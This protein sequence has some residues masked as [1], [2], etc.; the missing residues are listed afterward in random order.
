VAYYPN[1]DPERSGP[2]FS[3]APQFSAS[4]R[5]ARFVCAFCTPAAFTGAPRALRRRRGT[6]P[7]SY[8]S[9]RSL[10]GPSVPSVSNSS[11][12][13]LFSV[14]LVAQ[15]LL[16]TLSFERSALL[17][18]SSPRSWVSLLHAPGF[19]FSAFPLRSQRLC[20]MFLFPS[21]FPSFSLSF[22][23]S[24]FLPLLLSFLLSLSPSFFPSFSLSFF[25]SLLLSLSYLC[26]LC[27]TVPL[28]FASW[29]LIAGRRS[30]SDI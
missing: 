15:T 14:F 9:L 8:P 17:G 25:L 5:A 18:F 2:I 4:G 30:P 19:L 13:S 11:P 16:F 22:C 1:C 27:V 28:L 12:G 23:L 10:C 24:F 20:V 3:S 26:A 6:S 29:S 21:V 7:L